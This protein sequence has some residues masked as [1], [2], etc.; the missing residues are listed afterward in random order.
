M[1]ESPRIPEPKEADPHRP[2]PLEAG[3]VHLWH[4]DL[5]QAPLQEALLDGAE[6]ERAKKMALSAR[7]RWIRS[8]GLLRTVLSGYVGREP[9]KLHFDSL[10]EGKPHLVPAGGPHFNLS[11]ARERWVL[12]VSATFEVGVDLERTDREADLEAVAERIFRPEE[13]KA[14]L[15]LEGDARRAAFFR[16][17]T[18]REA[19]TKTRAEGMFT[20]SLDAEMELRPGHALELHGA[21][22]GHWTLAEIPM[23]EGWC[24]ALA[25]EGRIKSVLSFRVRTPA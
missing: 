25:A 16:A 23:P 21:A 13:T 10:G 12:A 8:R 5:D 17:W 19:L 22:A 18:G 2:P 4:A 6:A 1:Y 20:L 9:G 3:H 14:I 24:G 11:H 15:A 7:P